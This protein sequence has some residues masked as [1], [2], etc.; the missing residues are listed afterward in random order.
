MFALTVWFDLL[1]ALVTPFGVLC[2]PLVHSSWARVA[3][4]QGQNSG[5]MSKWRSFFIGTLL[6]P[7]DLIPN[8]HDTGHDVGLI[9]CKRI[10]PEVRC[11]QGGAHWVHGSHETYWDIASVILKGRNSSRNICFSTKCQDAPL[12]CEILGPWRRTTQAG[13]LGI[14]SH[15]NWN[16]RLRQLHEYELAFNHVKIDSAESASSQ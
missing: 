11:R 12:I 15:A 16:T 10:F 3:W 2:F 14:W 1:G 8:S 7:Q 5:F 6:N 4:A 13:A 9:F